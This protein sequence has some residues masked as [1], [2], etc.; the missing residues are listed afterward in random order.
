[1]QL[2][3]FMKYIIACTSELHDRQKIY[4]LRLTNLTALPLY[5]SE[6]ETH[7]INFL[8]FTQ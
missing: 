5:K 3:M 8:A 4:V 1:M 7:F 6:Y 2:M